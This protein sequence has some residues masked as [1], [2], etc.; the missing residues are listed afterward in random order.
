MVKLEKKQMKRA[1]PSHV[2]RN[3]LPAAFPTHTHSPLFWEQL[4]R[5]IATFGFLEEILGKAIFAFTGT[6]A[7]S[8]DE[9]KEALKAWAPKLEKALTD[10]LKTLADS[11]G[12]A[13]KE[14]QNATVENIDS[15]IQSIKDAADIRNILCHASWRPPDAEGRSLPFFVDRKRRVIETPMDIQYLKGVQ[16]C[17]VDLACGVID[18]VTQMGWTFPGNDEPKAPY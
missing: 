4:G 10:Q 15:L 2:N 5:T 18:S 9:I 13:V 8:S 11:Y 12:K 3:A 1:K 16:D 7:Y 6:R 14:N 17:I